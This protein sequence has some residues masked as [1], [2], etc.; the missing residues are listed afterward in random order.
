MREKRL[1]FASAEAEQSWNQ[2]WRKIRT[3]MSARQAE[4]AFRPASVSARGAKPDLE[5]MLDRKRDMACEYQRTWRRK[6]P[7]ESSGTSG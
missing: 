1:P 2:F 6:R 3:E 5:T 4:G 7:K